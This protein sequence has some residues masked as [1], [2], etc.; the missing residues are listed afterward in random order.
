VKDKRVYLIPRDPMNWFD[1]PP[2]FMRL[3]GARWLA[4]CFYPEKYP[5]NPEK[6]TQ[7]FYSLFLGYNLTDDGCRELFR[8]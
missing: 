1:R 6:E 5:W 3:I 8:P 7:T 2:S 4:H